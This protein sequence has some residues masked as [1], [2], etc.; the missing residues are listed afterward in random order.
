MKPARL[1]RTV[2]SITL[3]AVINLLSACATSPVASQ[4]TESSLLAA[5][6]HA[7]VAATAKQQQELRTLPAGQISTVNVNGKTHYIYP[8]R[9]N[10]K[11]YVGDAAAHQRLKASTPPE[12]DSSGP[13][14]YTWVTPG[15]TIPVDVIYDWAPF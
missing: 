11:L 14:R 4:S 1:T 7:K 5:G 15:A 3:A 6:F 13:V 12:R 8:D 9:A 10:G 2:L